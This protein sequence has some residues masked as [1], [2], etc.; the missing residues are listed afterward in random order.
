M[1]VSIRNNKGF[2]LIELMVVVAIIGVLAAIAVPNYQKFTAKSKQS[3]AKSNLSAVYS[4]MRAFNSE[5]QTYNTRFQVNGY[6]PTGLLRYQHG[7]ATE[8][9]TLPAAYPQALPAGQ[10]QTTT[11]CSQGAAVG[12]AWTNNCNVQTV[13]VAPGALGASTANATTFTARAQGDIDGDVT[14]DA[15]TIN[16]RKAFTLVTDDVNL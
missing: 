5:W 8:F 3:E 4:S 13:P 1:T 10:S 15:W 14:V 6:A 16:E 11:Y 2:S 12:V 7:F 9:T